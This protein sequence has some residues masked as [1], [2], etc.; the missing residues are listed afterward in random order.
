VLV[1]L[2]GP[3][4]REMRNQRALEQIQSKRPQHQPKNLWEP[5]E[6]KVLDMHRAEQVRDRCKESHGSGHQKYANPG[7]NY[8]KFNTATR[9]G[10][11]D[12]SSQSPVLADQLEARMP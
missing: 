5:I 10:N 9:T 6:R 3:D 7:L 4:L 8:A 2:G 12:A 1:R 11:A